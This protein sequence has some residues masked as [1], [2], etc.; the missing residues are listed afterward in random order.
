MTD[1]VRK[2]EEKRQNY[3]TLMEAIKARLEVV[4]LA[5]NGGLNLIFSEASIQ[6]IC[7]LNLRMI[8]ET[9]AVACLL[10]HDDLQNKE[11]QGTWD[12]DKIIKTLANLHED[13][14]PHPVK[15]EHLAGGA[16]HMNNIADGYLTRAELLQLIG[17]AGNKLHVG[18]LKNLLKQSKR[19]EDV[20]SDIQ[21]WNNKIVLLLNEHRIM[22]KNNS[23]YYTA[24]KEGSRN[25]NVLVVLAV[26]QGIT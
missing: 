5:L 13:F 26:P 24:L 8:A 14:F 16:V 17:Q 6:E 3:A 23:V 18:S 21:K 25:G 19:S 2:Q 12:A 20:F 4:Q 7:W 9:I 15:R 10:A 22:F 1:S 11:L